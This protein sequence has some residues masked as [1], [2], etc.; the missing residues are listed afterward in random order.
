MLKS[1]MMFLLTVLAVASPVAAFSTGGLTVL[2][3]PAAVNS[4]DN[5]AAFSPVQNFDQQ[6]RRKD[7]VVVKNYLRDIANYNDVWDGGYGGYGGY[8]M[9]GY[10]GGGRMGYGG[11]RLRRD[12]PSRDV[13]SFPVRSGS[14]VMR[15]DF[16]FPYRSYGGGYG[17]GGKSYFVCSK[18]QRKNT[19]VSLNVM[20]DT[21]SSSARIRAPRL[22]TSCSLYIISL[23]HDVVC[24]K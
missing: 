2:G 5:V 24:I 20:P 21:T 19:I 4:V 7:I 14:D 1:T 15:D 23:L 17:Y 12:I 6:T 13:S 16:L 9:G 8:G 22:V 18:D 3:K 11:L 10:G